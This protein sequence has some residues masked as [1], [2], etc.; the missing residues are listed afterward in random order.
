[1]SNASTRAPLRLEELARA[2]AGGAV[3]VRV[4]TKLAPAGGP[5]DKV[6]PPTYEGGAYAIERRRVGDREVDTVLLDSVQSQANRMEEALRVA[7]AGG[8][9]RFPLLVV[10][11]GDQFPR[12]G[13][14]TALDAPHRI[15]DAIFRDS[16][17]DGQAFRQSDIGRRFTEASVG[18]A[19][20]LYQHCPTALLFGVWDSTALRRRIGVKFARMLVSEIVGFDAVAGRRTASRIDPLQLVLE[21]G[22]IYVRRGGREPG[23]TTDPTDADQ[24]GKGNPV[25]WGRGSDRG[26]PSKIVHGNITPSVDDAGGVTISYAL[27]TTVLSLA[28]LRRLEFPLGDGAARAEVNAAG[29]T[30]LAALALAAMTHQREAGYD[31]RSRCLLVPVEPAVYELVPPEAGAAHQY[32]FSPA[33]AR[34]VFQE[35][36]TQARRAGLEWTEEDVVLTPSPELVTLLRS[37]EDIGMA[38]ATDTD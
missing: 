27:Q 18:R 10:N 17:L 21:A 29:Q 5:S 2:V 35:A 4:V 20:V 38:W 8:D 28:A 25:L 34:A 32:S 13:A 30:V 16:R 36:V 11:F 23:W 15:A 6:F 3:A 14:I 1:M 7:R 37:S 22:P 31:L 12:I 26:R 33:E 24:D 19:T 9:L